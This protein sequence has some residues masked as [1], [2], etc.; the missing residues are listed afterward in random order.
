MIAAGR[1]EETVVIERLTTSVGASGAV[2]EVWTPIATRRA[3]IADAATEEF[4]RGERGISTES[5]VVFRL[6]YVEGVTLADR[7]VWGGQAFDI[8]RVKE[9][10][11]RVGL[12]LTCEGKGL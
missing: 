10:G 5:V 4:V 2:A 7:V 11:R 12:E 9:V 6:W 3:E 1:L 8:K